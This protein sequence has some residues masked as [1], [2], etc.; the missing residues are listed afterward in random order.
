VLRPSF[1]PP[2]VRRMFMEIP[3]RFISTQALD[4]S[5]TGYAALTS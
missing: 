4:K 5:A 2:V 1:N 3:L